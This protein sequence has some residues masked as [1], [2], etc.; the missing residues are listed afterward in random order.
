MAKMNIVLNQKKKIGGKEYKP[1][2][3]LAEANLT[4][5]FTSKDVDRSM[6]MGQI[7]IVDVI[8]AKKK[9]EDK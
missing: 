7:K 6:Q 8:E 9:D 1:G 4:K 5:G 3:V 2:T